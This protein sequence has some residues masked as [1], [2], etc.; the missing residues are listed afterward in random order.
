MSLSVCRSALLIDY[1]QLQ[2][3]PRGLQLSSNCNSLRDD[4]EESE[5]RWVLDEREDLQILIFV[6]SDVDDLELFW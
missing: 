6:D 5:I 4:S 2:C 3:L 1:Y